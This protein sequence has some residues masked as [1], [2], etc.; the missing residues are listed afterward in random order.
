MAVEITAF[1][2]TFAGSL[3]PAA[4]FCRSDSGPSG[5]Q[6]IV[7][8]IIL[9]IVVCAGV[10]GNSLI[11]AAMAITPSLCTTANYFILVLACVD[12]VNTGVL[13]PIFIFTLVKGEWPYED[14]VCTAIGYLTIFC[15][16]TS[17]ITLTFLA[18]TR[19]LI[20]TKPKQVFA[21]YFKAK[22]VVVY[23]IAFLALSLTI[24]FIPLWSS[25][26]TVGFSFINSHCTFVI[27]DRS[28]WWYPLI[29]FLLCMTINV[30]I[31]PTFYLLTFHTV[32]KSKRT[33][34]A[35][36]SINGTVNDRHVI[37]LSP[38]EVTLTKKLLLLFLVFMICWFP[39]CIVI[40]ADGQQTVPP[41]IH[42]VTNLLIWLSSGINPYIYA[43]RTRKFRKVF[44]RILLWP[45]RKCRSRRPRG[46]SA[47]ENFG[48][49]MVDRHESQP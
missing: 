4:P 34:K 2:T 10:F 49:S 13:V 36:Q 45:W 22:F 37:S 21:R 23:L 42:E 46:A 44:R 15:L 31:I 27:C 39:N 16:A 30:G 5:A 17:E 41:I 20:V 32:A 1:N 38:Q 3:S 47:S 29:L 35:L 8:I 14:M 7:Q 43:F 19:Y 40:F 33:V 24:L 12:L 9:S 28:D 48:T 25:I 26:G 18:G 6:A 11:I